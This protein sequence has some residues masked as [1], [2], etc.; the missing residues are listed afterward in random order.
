M[1]TEGSNNNKRKPYKSHSVQERCDLVAKLKTSGLSSRKFCELHNIPA[2][3]LSTWVR[4]VSQG[5]LTTDTLGVEH[6]KRIISSPYHEVEDKLVKYI[7]LR[8]ERYSEDRC[9]LS[10]QYL[11]C[12]ALQFAQSIY[13][14]EKLAKFK[15]SPGFISNLLKRNELVSLKLRGEAGEVSHEEAEANMTAFRA[16]LLKDISKYNIPL[17]RIFNADQTG[18]FYQQL[19]N[20]MYCPKKERTSMRGVKQMKDKQR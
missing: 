13:D 20:R 16:N 18:L 3:T 19:P 1:V 15:A 14:G 2:S 17:D 11:Q 12:K 6:R 5:L 4:E 7:E 10:F 8:R 9:G